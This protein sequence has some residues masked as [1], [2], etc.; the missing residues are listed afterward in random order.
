MRRFAIASAL[1]LTALSAACTAPN[2]AASMVAPLNEAACI[3]TDGA[4]VP[5]QLSVHTQG[6][7]N[8]TGRDLIMTVRDASLT[9]DTDAAVATASIGGLRLQL[10]D[11]D[12]PVSAELPDGMKLRE[13]TLSPAEA[14]H[15]EVVA[16]SADSLT[17]H[18][19]GRL[20]Y[21]SK[22]VLSSG[23]LYPLGA[24][25]T[26]VS[27][28]NLRVTRGT[29]GNLVATLDATPDDNCAAIGTVLTLSHCALYVET[30]ATITSRP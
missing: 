19:R 22:M 11:V 20:R 7:L 1:T 6:F 14:W 3:A 4:M 9:L 24:S 29:D 27:D 25:Y 21:D 10:S 2:A 28:V 15:G 13:Q 16:K 23:A 12:L 17:V 18:V 8:P 30:P 5:S 26:Q